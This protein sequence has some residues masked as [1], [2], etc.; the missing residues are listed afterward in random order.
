MDV[1]RKDLKAENHLGIFALYVSF[2][3]QLIAG[4]IE[5]SPHLIPQFYE[6]KKFDPKK[7]VEGFSL[8][9]WGFFLKLVIADRVAIYVNAIYKNP[10]IYTGGHCLLAAYFFTYQIFCD[11]AGYSSIAIGVSRIFGYD[12]VD[13]FR[14]P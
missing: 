9:L 12:S 4:P 6:M 2:F 8:I 3:P 1:Y 14:H 13:N 5:R 11:F 10:D 7:F